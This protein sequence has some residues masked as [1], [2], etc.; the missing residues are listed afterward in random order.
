MLLIKDNDI[1]NLIERSGYHYHLN[2]GN[3]VLRP[4]ILQLYIDDR[5]WK[6]IETYTEKLEDYRYIGFRLDDLY[7]QVAACS[8]LI[9]AIRNGMSDIRNKIRANSNASNK[10]YSEMTVNNLPNNLKIFADLLN[11]LYVLLIDFD[12]KNSGSA[13]PIH[14]QMQELESVSRIL[15]AV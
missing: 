7:R 8:R 9:Q 10:I 2:I 3:Q 4:L 15:T 13:L 14:T 1:V 5:T 11:V 12:K 6:L